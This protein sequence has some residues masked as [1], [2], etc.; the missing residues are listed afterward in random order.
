MNDNL[1]LFYLSE[2]GHGN[3]SRF[4][5]ALEYLADDEEDLYRTVKARQLSMLGHVEFAFEGD[6]RWAIC[7]PTIAWL[8]KDDQLTGVLCGCR[9][10]QQLEALARG[11]LELDCELLQVPNPEGPDTILIT[12]PSN[13]VGEQLAQQLGLKSQPDAASRLAEILPDIEAYYDLCPHEPVPRGYKTE[14]YDLEQLRWLEVEE[15]DA[16]GFYRYTHYRREYRLKLSAT[17]VKVPPYVGIFIWLQHAKKIVFTYN[18]KTLTLQGPAS[19]I[20]PPLFGRA[21]IL[22]SG[23]LPHFDTTTYD[24]VYQDV[25]PAV[26][27]HL[28][29]KL[30]QEGN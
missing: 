3:W 24:H 13:S 14:Q 9:S 25:S 11:C 21:A 6:L 1:L 4:R 16:P 20:L 19:A 29:H 30:H 27:Y 7:E 8:S 26:A 17:C 10:E 28:L 5:Q 23:F 18:P 15:D 12:V 2:L 22:C